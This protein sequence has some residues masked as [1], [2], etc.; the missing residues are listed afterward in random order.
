MY[1]VNNQ[2][3]FAK[4]QHWMDELNTYAT[5]SNLVK[6]VVGNKIDTP[7]FRKVVRENGC[8]FA[9]AN[10]AL[11]AETSAKTS[12]GVDAVFE[13]L[14]R[15]ILQTP[16]LWQPTSNRFIQRDTVDLR[17]RSSQFRFKWGCC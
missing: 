17:R 7:L 14:T 12:Q 11:F 15:K 13:N 10:R 3:S 9:K 2:E 5:K 1:D 8:I 6:M 4:L 16:D